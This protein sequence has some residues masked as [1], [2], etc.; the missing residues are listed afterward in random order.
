MKNWKPYYLFSVFVKQDC[1]LLLFCFVLFLLS[2]FF[3]SA[4]LW[5]RDRAGEFSHQEE[6]MRNWDESEVREEVRP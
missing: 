6:K 1:P 3:C 2:C 4:G 5:K